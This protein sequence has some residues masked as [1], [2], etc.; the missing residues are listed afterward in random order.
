MG[1]IKTL[2]NIRSE[3]FSGII[4][5]SLASAGFS[6]LIEGLDTEWHYTKPIIVIIIFCFV[7]MFY[8][9]IYTKA[10]RVD[11]STTAIF[12]VKKNGDL[13]NMPDY[14]FSRSICNILTTVLRED[15]AFMKQWIT[16]FEEEQ[17]KRRKMEIDDEIDKYIPKDYTYALKTNNALKAIDA[18]SL[19]KDSIECDFL[20]WLSPFLFDSYS[21]KVNII[22]INQDKISSYLLKNKVL[23]LISKDFSDRPAFNGLNIDTKYIQHIFSLCD[24]RTNIEYNRSE[25]KSPDETTIERE[26]DGVL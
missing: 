4:I 21:N 18:P 3:F 2:N 13:I 10:R 17:E 19:L 15:K 6:T 25:L 8:C 12:V 14:I 26:E 1:P 9:Y 22:K 11:I 16:V 5:A 7:F 23:E 20:K 24:T